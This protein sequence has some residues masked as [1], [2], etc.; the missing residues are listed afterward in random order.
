M[1]T[2]EVE[3]LREIKAL[4]RIAFVEGEGAVGV[5]IGTGPNRTHF[6]IVYVQDEDTS[7]RIPDT[8]EDLP[9][10]K[11]ITVVLPR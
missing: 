7:Q 3:R 4:A 6:L 5:N 8:F 1:P 9:V 2:V 11:A 10:K